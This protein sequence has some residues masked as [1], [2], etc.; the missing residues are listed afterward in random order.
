M[1]EIH[2]I[3]NESSVISTIRFFSQFICHRIPERTFQ[4]KEHYFPVCSRCTGF[5]IGAFSYFTF[6]YFVY[7]EY[8]IYLIFIAFLMVIPTIIDGFTQ[9]LG[10][11]ESNNSL[12]LVTGLIG[13][14]GLS[15]CIKALKFAMS[16]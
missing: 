13:G 1:D 10:L 5:Y 8:N 7:V 3:K 16:S 9:F 12:R 15:I 6:V 2:S 11:R 4:I 14:L